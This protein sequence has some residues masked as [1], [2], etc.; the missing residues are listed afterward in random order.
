MGAGVSDGV[1]SHVAAACPT[2]REL[3][4]T[5]AQVSDAGGCKGVPR[6][7]NGRYAMAGLSAGVGLDADEVN[8]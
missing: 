6:G 1:L 4:L 5:L 7:M 8:S 2:L 3:R